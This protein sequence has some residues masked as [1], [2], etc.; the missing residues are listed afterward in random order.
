MPI[1]DINLEQI[2]FCDKYLKRTLINAHHSFYRPT[3]RFNEL[4]ITVCDLDSVEEEL[5]CEEE[6][7]E[8]V[9]VTY[10][11]VDG[12]NV[13]IHNPNLADVLF[14]MPCTLRTVILRHEI[15]NH[16]LMEIAKDLGV[17]ATMAGKYRKKALKFMKE[18]MRKDDEKT[19]KYHSSGGYHTGFD[20]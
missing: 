16:K 4:K 10:I 6:G 12:V 11:T 17:S 18:N 2:E 20:Q 7:Y 15:L 5:L 1:E 14:N 8:R 3:K 19:K 9:Y 13:P